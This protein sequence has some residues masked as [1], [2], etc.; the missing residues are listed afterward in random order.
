MPYRKRLLCLC[1]V[2]LGIS[3]LIPVSVLSEGHNNSKSVE[4]RSALQQLVTFRDKFY[5]AAV[6]DDQAWIVGYYGT[7]LHLKVEEK[8][9]HW[10]RQESLTKFPLFGVSFSDE[11]HGLIV[12]KSGLIL[13]TEN[14]GQS[15]QTVK[16]P[17]DK[18]LFS[19]Y[20]VDRKNGWAV[21]EFATILHTKDGG[22]TWEDQSLKDEDINLNKCF[23][24][25]ANTGWAVGEFATILHTRDGGVSWNFMH[26]DEMGVS[27]YDVFFKN[28]EEGLIAGQNGILYQTSDGGMNWKEIKLPRDDNLLGIGVLEG[29]FWIV[30]LRGTVI[31]E[32]GDGKFEIHRSV[33]IPDWLQCISF[34]SSGIG[35]IGGDH[36]RLLY[37]LKGPNRKWNLF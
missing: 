11:Q 15:W 30:G 1:V 20:L 24:L 18:H 10:K 9:F 8:S 6:S 16:C 13:Q 12:G 28:R 22:K 35:I 7:I 23:F 31:E 21:G 33:T 25:D 3:L 37:S 5:D 32:V 17:T 34:F 29:K 2:C 19:V 4:S 26:K 14:N 36:G 27:L